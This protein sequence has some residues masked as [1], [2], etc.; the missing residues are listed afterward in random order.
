MPDWLQNLLNDY[1]YWIV[2]A[3]VFLNN[4]GLPVPGD[5]FLLG[6]GFLTAE[7]MFH[8]PVTI[9]VAA[10]ACFMGGNTGYWAGRRYGRK[11]LER[12][13][14]LR[15]T[16]EK[17]DQVE[18]FLRRQGA[19]AVFFARFVALVHPV[20]GLLAGVGR[21]NPG[22]F[23]AY[24]LLGS[25]AY[26]MTY[27]LLGYFFGES[28]ELLKHWLGRTA[29]YSLAFLLVIIFLTLILRRPVSMLLERFSKKRW[30]KRF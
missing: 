21:I 22:P 16:P 11:I 26:A 9:T 4:I 23:L 25:E 27:A 14:F 28:W 10:T 12:V 30:L 15:M 29:I 8:L 6:A 13:G 2:F 3:V 19:K 18:G 1:G 17:I 20:T 7:D 24:N 5:T